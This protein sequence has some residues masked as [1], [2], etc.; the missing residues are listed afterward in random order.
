MSTTPLRKEIVKDS[1]DF[2]PL[3]PNLSTE[4]DE[5]DIDNLLYVLDTFDFQYIIGG[6]KTESTCEIY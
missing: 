5:L 2:S 6:R 3:F 1:A 4:T